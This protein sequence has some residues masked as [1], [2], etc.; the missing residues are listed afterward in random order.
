MKRMNE[1]KSYSFQS[2]LDMVVLTLQLMNC[3]LEILLTALQ[4]LYIVRQAFDLDLETLILLRIP[5]W[6]SLLFFQFTVQ[7]LH[8]FLYL[9]DSNCSF[10]EECISWN[11]LFPSWLK[12]KTCKKFRSDHFSLTSENDRTTENS[13]FPD[14]KLMIRTQFFFLAYWITGMSNL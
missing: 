2:L 14:L 13:L 12:W 10:L 4:W 9:R 7:N 8:F 11:S 6:I 3:L 1:Q 5:M